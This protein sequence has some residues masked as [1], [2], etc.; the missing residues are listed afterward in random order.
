MKRFAAKLL[1]LLSTFFVGVTT[2][3]VYNFS[4]ASVEETHY[5]M[6]IS[7]VASVQ[8]IDNGETKSKVTNFYYVSP[9]NE[10][11]FSKQYS[12]R[13][14]GTTSGGVVNYKVMCGDL[15]EY[16][17]NANNVSGIVRVY[18]LIDQYG[19]VEDAHIISGHRLLNNSALRAAR[20]TRFS[21]NMLGGEP[22]KVRGVLIYEFD[23]EGRVGIQ[24]DENYFKFN[25]R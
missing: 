6:E 14:K 17:Q 19:E 18:V 22:V 20:Q 21:P 7:N 25:R 12:A 13:V 2:Y 5:T 4:P 8:V 23:N 24:K 9:C 10:P 11:N 1:I 3:Y 15:P 16:S